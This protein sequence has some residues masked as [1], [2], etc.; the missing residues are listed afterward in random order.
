[1]FITGLR[2]VSPLYNFCCSI[3]HSIVLPDVWL[4]GGAE[5]FKGPKAL[6]GND[7]YKDFK[8][9][10]YNL[11]FNKKELLSNKKKNDKLLGVFRT[12]NLDV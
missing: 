8:K 1:M 9:A 12:G 11:V 7:Y 4:T 2:L 5:Y 3:S 6:N 10:G